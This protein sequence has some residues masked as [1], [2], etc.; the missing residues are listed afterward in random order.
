MRK[1]F[2]KTVWRLHSILG[3]VCGLVLIVVGVTGSLLVFRAE[4]DALLSPG[5]YRAQPTAAGRL[6]YDALWASARRALPGQKIVG[7]MPNPKAGWTDDIYVQRPGEEDPRRLQLNP[8]TGEVR[9]Q[10]VLRE[11]TL[12]GW[13]LELHY[14]LLAGTWGTFVTGLMAVALL[15]LGLSG[16]WLYRGFW[17]NFFTL[18]WGRSARI[19]FSDLHKTVGISSVGFNLIL[20]F[21]GAYWNLNTVYWKWTAATPF[22]P[23]PKAAA[24]PFDFAAGGISLDALLA[25]A[26]QELPGYRLKYLGLPPEQAGSITLY[27][28]VPTPNFLRGDYAS[29]V[30]FDARD[31]TLKQVTDSRKAGVWDTITDSFALL[32]YGTFGASFGPVVSFLVRILWSILGLAPGV[33]AVS[34]FLIW[35]SRRSPKPSFTRKV[36]APTPFAYALAGQGRND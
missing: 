3:L 9:G 11:Q 27:G 25:R 34:G 30:V 28:N 24:P 26:G 36:T 33:L 22:Y 32:H 4:V 17:R 21:T 19:F 2:T 29:H 31:G 5:L 10:P 7:W 35:R 6:S 1:R 15:V 8:Y 12:T 23:V 18:R 13:L 16:M 14:A 20:G